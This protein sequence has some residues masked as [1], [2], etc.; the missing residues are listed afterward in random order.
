[1]KLD[2]ASKQLIPP[3]AVNTNIGAIGLSKSEGT[4]SFIRIN[5]SP[6]SI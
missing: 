2:L 3:C 5:D 4:F 1:M 6:L